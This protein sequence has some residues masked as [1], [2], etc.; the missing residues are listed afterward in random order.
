[1]KISKSLRLTLLICLS[2]FL[3]YTSQGMAGSHS[4]P[5]PVTITILPCADIVTTYKKFYPLAV[6][7]QN[8]TGSKVIIKVPKDWEELYHLISTGETDFVYQPPHVYVQLEKYYKKSD[9]LTALSL[10]GERLHHALLIVR[11][12]SDIH[13]VED[14]RGK[15][16]L[17]GSEFSTIKTVAGKALLQRHGINYEKDLLEFRYGGSCDEIALNVYL[18][19]ADAGFVCDHVSRNLSSSPDKTWPIPPNGLRVI[20]ETEECPTWIFSVV[21]SA[22]ASTVSAVIRAL[23]SLRATQ[24]HKALLKDIESWGFAPILE[25]DLLILRKKF[26]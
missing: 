19:A 6:F 9:I 4:L 22:D 16:L 8:E 2:Y 15:S 14:L 7:L 26:L 20:G 25:S 12:D 10:R 3:L 23:L 1:M 5:P 13:K 18:K 17:F 11:S 21:K 24:N